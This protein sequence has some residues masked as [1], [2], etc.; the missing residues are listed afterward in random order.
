MPFAVN[1]AGYTRKLSL[2]GIALLREVSVMS[3]QPYHLHI[4]R[5]AS[6]SMAR[7]YTLSTEPTLF[8][9]TSL[10]RNWGRIGSGGQ[11]RVDLFEN[12]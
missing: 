4:Q 9:E 2:D 1:L 6:R 7:F 10:V 3:Q 8:G 11:R 5:I 12:D